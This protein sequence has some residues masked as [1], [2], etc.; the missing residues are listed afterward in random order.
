MH[1]PGRRRAPFLGL[2]A[3]LL[4]FSLCYASPA[5]AGTNS[6]SNAASTTASAAS[7]Q[8][9]VTPKPPTAETQSDP[10]LAKL[11]AGHPDYSPATCNVPDPAPDH[12]VCFALEATDKTRGLIAGADGPPATALGP[13]QIKAAY[14]LPDGGQGQTVAI[15]D[16][17]GDS[18]AESDLTAYRQ[19]YGLPAC[20]AANG[21]FRKTDQTGGAEYPTD[22]KGWA[23][24][25][26]LDLDAVSSACPQCH[27]L[28]VEAASSASSDLGTA[29][30][31]AVSL[32]AKYVSNSYG[33]PGEFAGEQADSDY[34]HPGV[35]IVASSGDTGNVVNWPAS[36]P[37]VVGVGGTT[38]TADPS[39]TRGWTET[40]WASGGSG[41]SAYEPQPVY[42]T[43]LATDC[44]KRATTDISAVADPNTG[45]AVYDTLGQPGWVQVG[46][47]SLSAPLI[48][49]MY[50]LAGAPAAGTYPVTYPYAFG[51]N[52]LFD[53]T[54]GSD[55]SCGNVLCTAGVGWDGPTGLGTPNGITALTL[56][57]F[58]TATGTLTSSAGSPVPNASVVLTDASQSLTFHATTDAQGKFTVGVAPG[59]Y[60]ATATAYGF[61]SATQA[62]VQITA[63]QTT[64]VNL[65]LATIPSKTV[66]GKVL[67]ST[68][69]KWGL[70]S[71][72]T[73]DGYPNGAI[74]SN[75][76]TG[77]YSVS[78]PED[79]KYTLHV[80]P[81]YP[82]Y[83][84]ADMS[85]T[86]GTADV[87]QNLAVGADQNICTAPGYAYPAQAD[88]EGWS[89]TTGKGGWTV[90]D[91]KSAADT[92][93][94]D[95]P[96]AM[97]N[98]TTGSGNFGTADPYD[99]N[100][101][102]EDTDFVSPVMDLSGQPT[103]D[104]KFRTAYLPAAST[105]A[106]VDG[107]GDGGKTWHQI[108]DANGKEVQ[109]PV[110][111]PLT[112]L[113]GHAG[114]QVRFHYS[115]AGLS[116][117][118]IDNVYV[119]TCRTVP[120]GIVEGNVTDDN[121]HQPLNGAATTDKANA[122]TTATSHPTPDDTAIADGF[123]W[124]FSE[125]AGRH[126]YTTAANR[127]A[128]LTTTAKTIA[129]SV[130]EHDVTLQAGR[131]SVRPS[132]LSVGE[133][134]GQKTQRDVTLTNTGRA[135]L[136]VTLGEQSGG[137][138]AP[139]AGVTASDT[140][141]PSVPVPLKRV[142]GDYPSGPAVRSES[143][144]PAGPTPAKQTPAIAPVPGTGGWQ[145][146][147]DYPEPI[148]DNAVGYYQGR[149][150]SVGGVAQIVGGV[151]LADSFMYD[152]VSASWTAIAPLPQ[153]LES[154]S[155]AFLNGTM[156]VVG[157]W[158]HDGKIQSTV[159]A[160]H[161]GSD[162]WTRV[163][164]LP[165]GTAASTAAVLNGS[166]YVIGGCA[167]DNCESL[168]S[169]AYRYSPNANSW[170]KLAD[171]PVPMQWGA[172]AGITAE[173]VCAGGDTHDSGG[174]TEGLAS[175][176]LF[177][178]KTDTWTQAA[179]IPYPDWGMSS[180][181]ANGQLQIVGGITDADGTNQ[182]EQY[183]PLNNVWSALP[184]AVYPT[185]RSG[186]ASC[187]MY[188]IGGSIAVGAAFPTGNDVSQV[189]PG[190]DQCGG[191]TVS[192]LTTQR[193][194][195]ALELAPGQSINV[196]VTLDASQITAPGS[197]T[198]ALT[199]TTDTPYVSNALPVN[200]HVAAPR[201]WGEVTGTVTSAA[202]ASRAAKP[203]PGATVQLC[204]ARDAASGTCTH[205]RYTVTT[206]AHGAYSLWLPGCGEPLA[207]V[208]STTG[209][210][211]QT[212]EVTIRRGGVFELDFT[213]AT[214]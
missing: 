109:G 82:G 152:P 119:G 4:G 116:L 173:V 199:F 191:D 144:D 103:A 117:W 28:L 38:L 2:I 72:I 34:D 67:D 36:D 141:T 178:P 206:D 137:S 58:G 44:A 128:T 50:A 205:P 138:T 145:A 149:A 80:T 189:L 55:G 68:G 211:S 40:A 165:Q 75:P 166:L 54:Q 6:P 73:I 155:A 43:G 33:I 8:G 163:A 9:P 139:G 56:G 123:Y 159:Y 214:S 88:F 21:C 41:C 148:M 135:P 193:N 90:T 95:D 151:A 89:G 209:Y 19:H 175:T 164:D 186:G 140:V 77:A 83:G 101:A 102:A 179:D 99:H 91:N 172:C 1:S 154:P 125:G 110:D 48:T 182:T 65:T 188:Q 190:F 207:V 104:L 84:T 16:A 10:R 143:T 157:G 66:S 184:N 210:A 20:T 57:S 198:G 162:S 27:I 35:A 134:L 142:P 23:E 29:E 106:E 59:T 12:A 192:W 174:H 96:N 81:I 183:D 160:Y 71:K 197:Y 114:V 108:W 51:G 204:A 25:T 18:T 196:R 213:L 15:V 202:T 176:Y 17:F 124:L 13:D 86:V 93:E 153:A 122:T 120:G 200:L 158:S 195:G 39:T 194:R 107:S 170:T 46:G 87:A 131:L 126:T 127:Y 112:G 14:H 76:K 185:F 64:T 161:P 169:A 111:V 63:N 132:S 187:G 97:W 208:A 94:F 130:V 60:S 118:Q 180:S 201:S 212:K 85:V 147:A 168:S 150:Y 32:G 156:Y 129:D 171:Y 42:Q 100:G 45:L 31:T 69:H 5:S 70:Y 115:G 78:L 62:G 181:G 24:E 30:K 133:E 3:G 113:A 53:V 177:H 203:L 7:S 49:A 105:V 167:A 92:W 74:Y 37:D 136:H 47:T 79:A 61:K 22:D 52:H 98:L 11:A 26:S 146:I 121:T